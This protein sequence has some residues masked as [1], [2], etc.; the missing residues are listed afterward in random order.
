MSYDK[1]ITIHNGKYEVI[2][3]FGC[4]C[5]SYENGITEGQTRYIGGKLM[6][7]YSIYRKKLKRDEINW[8]AVELGNTRFSMEDIRLWALT[9]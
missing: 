3:Y 8:C 2:G 7:A 1:K 6:Y 4:W 5:K 9:L